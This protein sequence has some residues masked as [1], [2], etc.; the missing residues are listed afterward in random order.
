MF[1]PWF[2]PLTTALVVI[3]A[4]PGTYLQ[5][6]RACWYTLLHPLM[7]HLK[8]EHPATI[9]CNVTALKCNGCLIWDM[10]SHLQCTN[11][12]ELHSAVSAAQDL[13]GQISLYCFQRCA[14][15]HVCTLNANELDRPHQLPSFIATT[16]FVR[17]LLYIPRAFSLLVYWCV[18]S[19]SMIH[20]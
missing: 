17:N 7:F 15:T 5:Y 14:Y 13:T 18:L 9:K 12:Y 11:D 6:M 16:N 8:L 20:R 2:V 10:Y 19:R 3:L 4:T 1:I